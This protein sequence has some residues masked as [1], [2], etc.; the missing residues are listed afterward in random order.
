MKFEGFLKL[1]GDVEIDYI[2]IRKMYEGVQG[3]HLNQAAPIRPLPSK[4]IKSH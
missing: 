4:E 2:H 1:T 3:F